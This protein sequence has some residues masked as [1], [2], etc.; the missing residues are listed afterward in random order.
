MYNQN[1]IMDW[2]TLYEKHIKRCKSKPTIKGK[3]YHN[4]HI[5]PRS[6]GGGNEPENLIIL[7]Y[8]DH[9]IAHYILYKMNPSNSN[10]I[11]YR[12]MSGIDENKK[13]LVEKLKLEAISKRD[14]GKIGSPESVEKARQ[15]RLIT[16]SK[17]SS[18]ERSL[19]FG[20][21]K[22]NHPFWG[23][24]RKGEKAANWGKS[25]GSYEVWTPKN[26]IL[27]FKS[28]KEIMGFGFDEGTIK[29]NRNK[30]IIYKPKNGGRPS[31]WVG[32]EIKYQK[33]IQYGFL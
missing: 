11:S 32:Y 31:K 21:H 14:L 7:E 6:S 13:Q 28:L 25:K 22:E 2:V 33:N 4:H 30:G 24:E 8:N 26:E 18:E 5:T 17:M 9:V 1:N 16:I 10:W 23:K 27:Y 19:K 29:R 3:T 15:K 20:N 12:L